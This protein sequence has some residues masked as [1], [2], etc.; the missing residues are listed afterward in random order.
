MPDTTASATKTVYRIHYAPGVDW[1]GDNVVFFFTDGPEYDKRAAQP[2]TEIADM[3]PRFKILAAQEAGSVPLRRVSYS[4]GFDVLAAGEARFQH[5]LHQGNLPLASLT[6]PGVKQPTRFVIEALDAGCPFPGGYIA[7]MHHD[8]DVDR[9]SGQPFNAPSITLD[10]ARLSSGEVFINGQHDPASRPKPIARTYVDV[11]PRA[12]A[13]DGLPGH[14]RRG[15][16]VGPVHE[17]SGQQRL[18]LPQRGLGGRHHRLHGELHVRA[19]AGP[20]RARLRRRRVELQRQ[21]HAAQGADQ[22]RRRPLPARA[23]D[24][25]TFPRP[26]GATRRSW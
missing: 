16:P 4:G 13:A 11:T 21:H 3:G 26:A 7:A 17:V 18:H 12:E 9:T 22:D 5:V 2:A 24:R 14:L 20:V 10:E 1:Q 25:R 23:H 15:R 6:W 8:A 19:D